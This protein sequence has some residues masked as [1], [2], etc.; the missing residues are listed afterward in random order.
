MR[1]ILVIGLGVMGW[2]DLLFRMGIPYD[3]Q[4][5]LDLGDRLMAFIQEKGH[6]ACQELAAEPGPFPNWSGSMPSLAR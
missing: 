5:A 4:A 6:L 1:W 2:A 3:S